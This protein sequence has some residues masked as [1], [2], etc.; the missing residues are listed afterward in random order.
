[1][2]TMGFEDRDRNYRLLR[3]VFNRTFPSE[4]QEE[5]M[6]YVTGEEVAQAPRTQLRMTSPA[7]TPPANGAIPVMKLPSELRRSIFADS[8]PAKDVVHPP[9]CEDI[10]SNAVSSIQ[11]H[12]TKTKRTRI[13]DL[14]TVNRAICQEITEVLYEE[15]FFAIHV[16]E[17]MRNGG[18]EFQDVGRQ[19]LQY[20]DD[21]EDMRF[22]KFHRGDEF[23]FQRLKKIRIQVFPTR[24]DVVKH[25]AINTYFINMALCRLLEKGRSERNRITSLTIEFVL[26][27]IA[28][29]EVG[30]GAIQR[31]EQYWWDSEKQQPRE[32]S[33]HNLSN[34]ML[35][36]RPFATLTACHAVQIQLPPYVRTHQPTVDFVQSLE[37][38]MTSPLSTLFMDDDL[39]MKI[40]S[41][42]SAMEEFVLYTLHGR[43]YQEVEKLTEAEM[44]EVEYIESDPE[45]DKDDDNLI[46]MG[47]HDLSP[48][49]KSKGG[50]FKRKLYE[51]GRKLNPKKDDVKDKGSGLGRFDE[52]EQKAILDSFNLTAE[53]TQGMLY[54]GSHLRPSRGPTFGNYSPFSGNGRTLASEYTYEDVSVPDRDG[55]SPAR[56]SASR[57]AYL[58]PQPSNFASTSY[59]TTPNATTAS[60]PVSG[61]Y[62][63]GANPWNATGLDDTLT[64]TT[65]DVPDTS[66]EPPPYNYP[67]FRSTRPTPV[68]SDLFYPSAMP[69]LP[70]AEGAQNVQTQ[71]TTD[72]WA[73]AI[74]VVD[75]TGYS[76]EE[77]S[78][79][80]VPS[81]SS[82]DD[83]AQG[84]DHGQ[85]TSHSAL[86][87]SLRDTL[88]ACGRPNG[89]V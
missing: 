43:G 19:P 60:S 42:R 8:L 23:G 76:D 47:K 34:I 80:Q 52:G 2:A 77:A 28:N 79:P 33:I 26:P 50:D 58:F 5:I 18:I 36:L 48:F 32:T 27:K 59:M 10:I 16:H 12:N 30:R 22:C 53:A 69:H 17:G 29:D 74:K 7:L 61:N 85:Q 72:T 11:D 35:V 39:E 4:V 46:Y 31:A 15:R 62:S 20:L 65:G 9:R 70:S 44:Q 83:L 87:S 37:A 78:T 40:E 51:F 57:R 54:R 75:L 86:S 88:K 89:G 49:S 73:N 66:T 67:S 56:A 45:S 82:T 84:R 3:S 38:S 14:M 13:S 24:E 64:A 71:R 63:F 1:M 55:I 21:I 68:P 6:G 41:A 81:R 25:T